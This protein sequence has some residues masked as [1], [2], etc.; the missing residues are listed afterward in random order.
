MT[1]PEETLREEARRR[2][3]ERRDFPTHL[4]AYLVVNA[5]LVVIWALTG[6]GFF[7]PAFVLAGWGV[8]LFMHA[9]T[10]YFQRPVS[11]AEIEQEMERIRR[12]SG[13]SPA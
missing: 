9:W 6:Q 13:S 10:V 4:V 5:M 2:V 11:E 3:K 1:V 12:G 7:W 8:G